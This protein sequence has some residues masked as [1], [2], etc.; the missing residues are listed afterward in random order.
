MGVNDVGITERGEQ[1]RCDWMGGVTTML[2]P[3]RQDSNTQAAAVVPFVVLI[4]EC[5]QLAAHPRKPCGGSGEL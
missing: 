2:P 5:N 4:S 3:R 1:P